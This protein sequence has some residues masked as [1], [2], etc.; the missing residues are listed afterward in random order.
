M[1]KKAPFSLQEN[2]AFKIKIS[3]VFYLFYYYFSNSSFAFTFYVHIVNS[4]WELLQISGSTSA[5]T[6]KWNVH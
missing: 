6:T 1:Y 4:F 2:G 5:I 3:E